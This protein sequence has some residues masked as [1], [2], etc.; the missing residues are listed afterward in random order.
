MGALCLLR[1]LVG[2]F[3]VGRSAHADHRSMRQS[4][5]PH[6]FTYH[7]GCGVWEGTKLITTQWMRVGISDR[8]PWSRYGSAGTALE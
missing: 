1:Y 2:L 4:T 6:R 5:P 8:E 7:T 3:N